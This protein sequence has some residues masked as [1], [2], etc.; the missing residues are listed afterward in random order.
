MKAVLQIAHCYY[1]PF[2]DCARQ[3]SALFNGKD[4][5]VTTVYLTGEQNSEVEQASESDEVIFLGFS[6]KDVAGLKLNA[7]R[8]VRKDS[9]KTRV[10]SSVSHIGPSLH[11]LLCLQLV[12]Q[13]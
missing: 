5:R 1:P 9:S 8:K 11:M 10:I 12:F 3:Y 7:I 13:L 6:S 2:L 4:Y